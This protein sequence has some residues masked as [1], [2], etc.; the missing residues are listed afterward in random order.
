MPTVCQ[1]LFYDCGYIIEPGE[2]F[3]FLENVM[4]KTK[5]AV[6]TVLISF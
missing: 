3:T 6:Y 1:A 4:K 5:Q 2:V